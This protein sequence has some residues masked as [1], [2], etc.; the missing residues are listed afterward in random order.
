MKKLILLLGVFLAITIGCGDD[1]SAD[2]FNGHL[3]VTI[4]NA[5]SIPVQTTIL[6]GLYNYATIDSTSTDPKS[7][8]ITI[9]ETSQD[10]IVITINNIPLKTV[11][12][13][14]LVKYVDTVDNDNSNTALLPETGDTYYLHQGRTYGETADGIALT[15]NNTVSLTLDYDTDFETFTTK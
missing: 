2:D 6:T 5:S 12:M 1:S 14:I 8:D 3:E 7:F 15:N 13:A 11:Y 10:T 9:I 4:N